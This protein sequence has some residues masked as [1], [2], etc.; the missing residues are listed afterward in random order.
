MMSLGT[1]EKT[2]S[3]LRFRDG[4]VD[5]NGEK[6]Q[7]VPEPPPFAPSEQDW[8]DDSVFL[9]EALFLGG[10]YQHVGGLT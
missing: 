6:T 5:V 9:C 3:S 8:Q 7:L 1:L 4:L 10:G 2:I